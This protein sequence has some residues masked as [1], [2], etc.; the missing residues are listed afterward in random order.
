M[1]HNVFFEI[2]GKKMKAVIEAKNA[3]EAK[4]AVKAKIIFH[5]IETV[6][7]DDWSKLFGGGFDDIC[8]AL[9]I[10]PK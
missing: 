1:K 7:V 10:K 8:S 2:Y 9:G 4:E 3:H 5:K 6:P